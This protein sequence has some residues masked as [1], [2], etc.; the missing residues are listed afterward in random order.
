MRPE[1]E[2]RCVSWSV[3]VDTKGGHAHTHHTTQHPSARQLRHRQWR[4]RR[5]QK[6]QE[7]SN[8]PRGRR[9]LICDQLA[10][11]PLL[12]SRVLAKSRPKGAPGRLNGAR[13]A[14]LYQLRACARRARP[15]CTWPSCTCR[16]PAQRAVAVLR[17]YPDCQSTSHLP[18]R[19]WLAVIER[20]GRGLRTEVCWS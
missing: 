19:C 20:T 7:S 5:R 13:R 4:R 14:P 10:H 17:A 1:I 2:M 11:I 6:R 15:S 18:R 8:Q 3:G 9:H 12:R 16:P